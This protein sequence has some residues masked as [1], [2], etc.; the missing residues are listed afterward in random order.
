M[1]ENVNVL[2]ELV[3]ET[4]FSLSKE[5]VVS[6]IFS[7]DIIVF[8]VTIGGIRC[9]V[10]VILVVLGMLGVIVSTLSVCEVILGLEVGCLINDGCK[11]LSV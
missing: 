1:V 8:S 9:V 5:I 7:V 11:N 10:T 6:S 4:G 3:C 2:K